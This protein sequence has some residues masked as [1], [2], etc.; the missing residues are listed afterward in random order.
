MPLNSNGILPNSREGL[1]AGDTQTIQ[2]DKKPYTKL[3]WKIGSREEGTGRQQ[4]ILFAVVPPLH[5]PP[6]R[7]AEA[8]GTE[9]VGICMSIVR[10]SSDSYPLSLRT[11][12]LRVSQQE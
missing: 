2:P 10:V 5:L 7:S 8:T 3:G 4:L 1:E 11:E 12:V 6:L 9:E